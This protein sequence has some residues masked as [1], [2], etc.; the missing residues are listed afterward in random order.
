MRI[1]AHQ[2]FWDLERFEYSWMPPAPSVLRRNYLPPDLEPILKRNRF[3]GSVVV[4]AN[5][6]VAETRWLLQLASAHPIILGVVGWVDLTDARVGDSLDEFQRH[7]KFKGVRHIVQDEP[8]VNWLLRGDVLRG[9]REVARRG[10]PYDL[11]LRPQHLPLVPRLA[12]R[13]PELR[14]VI[15]HIAKPRIAERIWSGWARDMESAARIPQV[16]CKLSGMITEADPK[17]WKA[18]DLRPY[19]AHAASLFGPERLMFGS[20]WPVCLLACERWKQVLAA[21]T[22]ALGPQTMAVRDRIFGGTAAGFYRL[23]A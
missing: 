11:L 19:V 1:D 4:Q 12:D 13:V 8:D 10:L 16:W 17:D 21:C 2:H 14:M 15:D 18:A 7:P 5:T 23:G 6:L 3:D 20:D 22:Q 9:L